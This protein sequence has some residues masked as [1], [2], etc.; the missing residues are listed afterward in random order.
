MPTQSPARISIDTKDPEEAHGYLQSTYVEHS[1]QLSGN[2]DAFRFRHHITDGGNF[3]VARY[4]HSMNCRVDTDPFGYLLAD[5]CSAASLRLQAGHEE[6]APAVGELFLLDPASPMRIHWDEFRAGLVKLDL[7][8]VQR[9]AVEACGNPHSA[10]ALRL[11]AGGLGGARPA[12]AGAHPLR[13][14]R[15]LSQ[16]ARLR[17][18][19]DLLPHDAAARRDR[20]GDLPEHHDGG[21][22]ER[23]GGA[24][25]SAVRRAVAFIDDHAGEP[26]GLTE[27]AA[28]ARLGSRAVQEAFRRHLDTT[29]MAYLRRVRLER[30]HRELQVADP[31]WGH[32]RRGRG[33]LGVRPPRPLRRA[34]PGQ[35]RPRT[36]RHAARLALGGPDRRGR[37]G[38]AVVQPVMLT[39]G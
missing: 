37:G 27:I 35:L 6:L 22:P 33:R 32:R 14:P 8:V 16:R 19:A 18:P 2:S 25:A 11:V 3:F 13:E 24:D 30:V 20:A 5:R 36:E 7:G 21:D 26:I 34:L 4:E 23:P 38:R 15:L 1:V 9:V 39:R 10:G 17:K 28:A 29:P 12:L 31:A